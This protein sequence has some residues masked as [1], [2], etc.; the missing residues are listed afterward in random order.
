MIS[1]GDLKNDIRGTISSLEGHFATNIEKANLII[2]TYC[3]EHQL[4]TIRELKQGLHPNDRLIIGCN[5]MLYRAIERSIGPEHILLIIDDIPIGFMESIGIFR[6]MEMSLEDLGV[7]RDQY[8]RKLFDEQKF[9]TFQRDNGFFQ[10]G[11]KVVSREGNRWNMVLGTFPELTEEE[12]WLDGG[13]FVHNGD[14]LLVTMDIYDDPK[15]NQLKKDI[16][17]QK[18]SALFGVHEILSLPNLGTAF[19]LPHADMCCVWLNK[20]ALAI[21][22]F[23]NAPWN[24]VNSTIWQCANRFANE[25]SEMISIVKIPCVGNSDPMDGRGLYCQTVVTDNAIY[26][27]RY[28]THKSA[29]IESEPTGYEE[30]DVRAKEAFEAA[31]RV[32]GRARRP[33]IQV[34]CGLLSSRSGGGLHCLT[35][36]LKGRP[37]LRLLRDLREK[38]ANIHPGD[39]NYYL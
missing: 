3:T 30:Y 25:C 26:I 11:D 21:S 35:T 36:Q 16:R 32:Y 5:P 31:E 14:D 1:L 17:F 9:T 19:K 20:N 39:D 23:V 4:P 34:D 28:S 7:Q 27:P 10:V 6:M 29:R 13:N 24:Q 33:V 2:I 12:M 37:A 15:V 38:F 22:E 8:Y 18:M